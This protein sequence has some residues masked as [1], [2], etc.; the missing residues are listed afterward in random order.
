MLY[1]G[2]NLS[3]GD[4]FASGKTLTSEE[5]AAVTSRG[6]LIDHLTPEFRLADNSIYS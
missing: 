4:F 2:G 3:Y 1:F 5:M 6:M